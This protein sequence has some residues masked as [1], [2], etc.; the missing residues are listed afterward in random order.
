MKHELTQCPNC[1]SKKL[2]E[3][4]DGMQL[5][6]ECYTVFKSHSAQD[7]FYKEEQPKKKYR[8]HKPW[9]W[10]REK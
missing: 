10:G 6:R 9:W 1:K 7:A 3:T 2:T 8:F 4:M 5:C